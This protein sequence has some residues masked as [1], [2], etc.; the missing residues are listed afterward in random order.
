MLKKINLQYLI[1]YFGIFPY[2]LILLDKY[3]FFKIKEEIIINFL[4]YYTLIILVFIGSANWN[5]QNKISNHI[6]IYGFI[7]SL[8]ALIIIILNL[9][10]YGHLYILASII[11]FLFLQLFFDYI[12]IY[13]NKFNR[14]PFYFLR[15]PLTLTIISILGLVIYY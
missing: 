9:Y 2:I 4:I 13:S 1:S 10:N 14:S 6:I 7:P 5:L 11:L 3:L 8:F 15:L 12:L